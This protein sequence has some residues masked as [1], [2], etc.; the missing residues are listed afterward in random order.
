MTIPT[1]Q[2]AL[3]LLHHAGPYEIHTIP[4]LTLEPGEVLV[5]VEAAG[6][7]PADWKMRF[8]EY[9][10]VLNNDYPALEGLDVAGTI[11]KLGE[12]VT[13]FEIGDKVCV[14]VLTDGVFVWWPDPCGGSFHQGFYNKRVAGFQQYTA[15]AADLVA[16]VIARARNMP[17]LSLLSAC[18]SLKIYH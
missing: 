13:E 16:K 8:T 5:R 15:V 6:L 12:D 9:S 18:R 1:E 17:C 4:V 10:S 7:N 3:R 11:V 2:K 14:R